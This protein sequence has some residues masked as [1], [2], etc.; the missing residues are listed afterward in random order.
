MH[1]CMSKYV[2]TEND[3]GTNKCGSLSS[4]VITAGPSCSG[5]GLCQPSIHSLNNWDLILPECGH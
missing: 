1:G 4:C 5:V 3:K 2:I